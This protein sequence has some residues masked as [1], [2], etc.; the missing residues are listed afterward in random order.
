VEKPTLFE[1]NFY[2]RYAL[3][4]LFVESTHKE[5]ERWIAEVRSIHGM[6]HPV[7]AGSYI[8]PD[9]GRVVSIDAD[10]LLVVRIRRD[11]TGAYFEEPVRLKSGAWYEQPRGILR[12]R[13]MQPEIHSELQQ[14]FVEAAAQGNLELLAR[15]YAR[16]ANVDARYEERN[17]LFAGNAQAVRWLL[18]HGARPDGFF[19]ELEATPL[20]RAVQTGN[21]EVVRLLLDAGADRNLADA[22]E[23][24]PLHH[25][26]SLGLKDIARALIAKGANPR[27]IDDAGRTPALLAAYYGNDAVLKMLLRAGVRVDD[28]DRYGNTMLGAAAEGGQ[29][30]TARFL[31]RLGADVN[32]QDRWHNSI[33]DRARLYG[34]NSA[35]ESL[36][37]SRGARPGAPPVRGS[38]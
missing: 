31:I 33:L 6:T 26:A 21:L 13:L 8:G 14:S 32:A 34:R 3:E 28:A 12:Q 1:R 5:G 2:E 35:L 37:V 23:Y 17:A 18:A 20:T 22:D 4:D 24:T 9:M 29:F 11:R 7:Q 15:L 38:N 27:A 16:G 36:L 19:S 30:E 25:A 10:G